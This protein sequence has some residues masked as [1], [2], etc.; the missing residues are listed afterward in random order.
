MVYAIE[1]RV[2]WEQYQYK[3]VDYCIEYFDAVA[4]CT[5]KLNWVCAEASLC[6]MV[7]YTQ[8]YFYFFA[9]FFSMFP[10]IS[11]FRCENAI[12]FSV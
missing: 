3:R 8:F 2:E 11:H 10:N 6:M 5:W 1:K 12:T 9:F 7:D 4:I